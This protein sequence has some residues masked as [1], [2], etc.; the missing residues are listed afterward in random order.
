MR[1]VRADMNVSLGF[2]ARLGILS[3]YTALIAALLYRL[4]H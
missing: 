3:V 1:Q 4:S 2:S